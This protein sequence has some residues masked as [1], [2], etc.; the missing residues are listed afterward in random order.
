ME[1]ESAPMGQVRSFLNRA[2]TLS[3]QEH[4]RKPL[5]LPRRLLREQLPRGLRL[6]S[7]LHPLLW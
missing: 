5:Q 3:S 7:V 2:R 1:P 6:A 4:R